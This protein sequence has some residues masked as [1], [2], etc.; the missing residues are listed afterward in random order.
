MKSHMQLSIIIV[1]YKSGEHLSALLKMLPKRADWEVIVIDNN[2]QNRGYGAGLNVGA[3]KARGEFLLF[4]NPDVLID[5]K[6]ISVLLA[7]SKKHKDVGIVGPKYINSQHSTEQS[8]TQFPSLLSGIIALSPLNTLFPNNPVSRRY[9]I[10]DWDRESTRKVDVISGA[11]LMVRNSEFKRIGTFDANMFL[12]WEEFDLCARYKDILGLSAAYV[13]E[14]V[15]N[16]P[17]EVSMK[18]SS[19]DVHEHFVHSRRIYL[20]KHLGLCAL[21]LI[22]F[23]LG[24]CER[25]RYVVVGFLA[26]F[27][28]VW[29]IQHIQFIGD[30]G[31]DYLEAVNML[32]MKTFPVMGIPSSIPRFLQGPFNVWFDAVSFALGGVNPYSPVL[33][34]AVLTTTGVLLLMKFASQQ[35]G[36]HAG[37][38]VGLLSASMI[39]G[40]LQSR[41]P[42]YLFAIPLFLTLHMKYIIKKQSTWKTI[43]LTTLT[44]WLIFQ[45]EMALLPVLIPLFVVVLRSKVHWK[46]KVTAFISATAIGLLPQILYDL[47]HKCAQLCGLSA[48]AVYRVVAFS[49]FDGKHGVAT[50]SFPEV[51]H[52]ISLQLHRVIGLGIWSGVVLILFM[53]CSALA[54]K[55][56][57]DAL[58]FYTVFSSICVLV[59]IIVHGSPSEAYFPPFLVFIPLLIAFLV[60]RF[61]VTV[62]KLMVVCA[63]IITLIYSST[64]LSHQFYAKPIRNM[65]DAGQWIAQDAQGES[66]KLLSYD[67][68]AGQHTYLDHFKF[69]IQMYGGKVAQDGSPYIVSLDPKVGLPTIDILQ[70]QFGYVRVVK[71]LSN[72]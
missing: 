33:F 31:R 2:K 55:K 4:L 8:S 41:M 35:Y 49:G 27:L 29:N 21:I 57:F 54:L 65:M 13:A 28:R 42:F 6:N 10:K 12:Y 44:Y 22:E 52:N 20:K 72:R 26:L 58:A 46:N 1:E 61:G 30:V 47:T 39:S 32:H 60:S 64:L 51:L 36:K 50:L 69:L 15:A 3:Q 11:A 63:F 7:Y 59:A 43:F 37:F 62:Q 40:V 34:S 17:R 68:P 71:K 25:W 19:E 9:W 53:I 66:V 24:L 14:S 38:I 67:E 56:K 70:Q 45:W 23:W 18:Q 16:H 5:E 48:W